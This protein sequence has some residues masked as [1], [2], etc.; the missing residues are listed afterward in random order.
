M[1][2]KQSVSDETAI[3]NLILGIVRKDNAAHIVPVTTQQIKQI[4]ALLGGGNLALCVPT[5]HGGL[6]LL[7]DYR[8]PEAE[9]EELARNMLTE[10]QDVYATRACPGAA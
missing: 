8:R 6:L 9:L 4:E 7:L 3:V 5:K 10:F 2:G 1:S